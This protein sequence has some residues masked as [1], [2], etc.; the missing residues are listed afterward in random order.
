MEFMAPE[1]LVRRSLRGVD[2]PLQLC[3]ALSLSNP[4][5]RHLLSKRCDRSPDRFMSQ[6]RERHSLLLLPSL[7]SS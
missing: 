1:R 3:I 4:T 6:Q 2:L 5:L 7:L